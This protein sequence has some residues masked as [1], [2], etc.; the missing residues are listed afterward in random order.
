[1]ELNE[2]AKRVIAKGFMAYKKELKT[3][4][5]WNIWE[6]ELYALVEIEMVEKLANKLDL[7]TFLNFEFE[8]Q[9]FNEA[10]HLKLKEYAT[11][12]F[13]AAERRRLDENI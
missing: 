8:Q 4:L 11:E 7:D 9:E 12:G 3:E 6:D 13:C 10:R 5:N 1:M 2:E